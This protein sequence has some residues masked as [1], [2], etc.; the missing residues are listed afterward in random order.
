MRAYLIEFH[1]RQIDYCSITHC[2][3]ALLLWRWMTIKYNTISFISANLLTSGIFRSLQLLGWWIFVDDLMLLPIIQ[4][5]NSLLGEPL[6]TV[7]TYFGSAELIN[8]RYSYGTVSMASI[9][10]R[11]LG[12][13]LVFF[14]NIS[15]SRLNPFTLSDQRIV[16]IG[17]RYCE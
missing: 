2:G 14:P 12:F 5:E 16:E 3:L 4:E 13:P 6:W 1:V 15:R 10:W 17:R 7:R 11:S 8:L 9:W